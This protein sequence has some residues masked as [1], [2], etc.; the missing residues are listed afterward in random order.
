MTAPSADMTWFRF[1]PGDWLTDENVAV[2]SLEAQGA[3]LV[4]LC[5]C[6]REGSVP[7]DLGKLARLL[8]IGT[9]DAKRIWAELQERFVPAPTSPDRLQNRRL[10]RERA[11]AV[12]AAK[13]R[14]QKGK[15]AADSRW[16]TGRAMHEQCS[17]DAPSM[18]G[19]CSADPPGNAQRCQPDTETDNSPPTPPAEPDAPS[20]PEE[21][22][23]R[24]PSTPAGAPAAPDPSAPDG[25][26]DACGGSEQ[27]RSDHVVHMSC[28]LA[29]AGFGSQ[30]ERWRYAHELRRHGLDSADVDE[31]ARIAN[32]D[33][34]E[35]QKLFASWVRKGLAKSVLDEE[36][37]K[38]KESRIRSQ[39]AAARAAAEEA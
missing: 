1:F 23:G 4:L 19:A 6:W 2:M 39:H 32:R 18:P 21:P 13:V 38:A 26:P 10:E 3:Y 29:R 15:H 7:A 24:A 9:K 14:S 28:S 37:S 35:P 17:E 12:E 20:M 5:H 16:R 8:R 27:G 33:G 11:L 25:A 30:G 22:G 31:L 36:R 34:H